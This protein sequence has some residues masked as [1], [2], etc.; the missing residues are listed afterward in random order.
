M[1]NAFTMSVQ[2]SRSAWFLLAL[3]LFIA[4][5]DGVG[6]KRVHGNGNV[7]TDD[8]S[9]S[10]FKAIDL[11]V[12]G[13]IYL[14]EGDHPAIKLEGDDNLLQ[15]IE[16]EQH[17]DEVVVRSRDGVNLVPSNNLKIYVTTPVF[18]KI[19]ASCACN[20][21]SDSRIT[22]PD[23]LEMHLSGAGNIKMEVDAPRVA[24][25]LSG[26]GDIHLKGQ[27]KDLSL[28]LSGA[29]D[30]KCYDLL[31]ENTDVSI[32]GI[33]SAEVYA[34]VKLTASV[35]GAGSVEYKGNAANVEQHVSGAGSVHKVD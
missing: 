19:A 34:S 30:A 12:S 14:T 16:V 18:D 7:K 31:A 10:S 20:I 5:C 23:G 27:T 6:G 3:P 17:G 21:E 33:G 9:V 15:L 28:D 2:R 32:S 8:R 4:S 11:R 24:V 29:G 22:S 13:D 26:A 1:R 35:S 25:S